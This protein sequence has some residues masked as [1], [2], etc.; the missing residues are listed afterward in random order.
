MALLAG[1][2]ILAGAL[3][4]VLAGMFGV[5]G[6]MFIVPALYEVFRIAGVDESVRTHLCVGHPRSR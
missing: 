4:G 1:G 5:G 2:L 3:T 6:G